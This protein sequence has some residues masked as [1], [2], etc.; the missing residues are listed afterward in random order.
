MDSFLRAMTLLIPPPVEPRDTIGDW[1]ALEAEMGLIF[2][3][4]YKQFIA[5]YGTG[6][7][8]SL[9]EIDSP[10]RLAKLYQTSTREAWITRTG[11]YHQ[12]DQFLTSPPPYSYYPAIPGLLPCAADASGDLIGWLTN[13]TPE[14]WRIVYRDRE[15]AYFEVPGM[16][17]VEFLVAAIK[18]QAPVP[19]MYLSKNHFNLPGTFKPY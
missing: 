8:C 7:L 13:A 14:L 11:V 1:S 9:I 12:H 17:F 18:E 6:T 2:P 16:G 5:L 4:D 19:E 10:F 3:E 15:N